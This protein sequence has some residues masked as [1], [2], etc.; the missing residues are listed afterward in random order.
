[1]PK[2]KMFKNIMK[3]FPF[4]IA[5]AFPFTPGLLKKEMEA[6][7]KR[8]GVSSNF[9]HLARLEQPRTL[10]SFTSRV[11]ALSLSCSISLSLWCYPTGQCAYRPSFT[12]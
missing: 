11:V 1:V 8:L 2:K 6:S 7:E 3:G 10:T 5:H 12:S 9:L 4:T